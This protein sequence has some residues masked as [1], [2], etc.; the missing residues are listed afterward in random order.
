MPLYFFNSTG[1]VKEGT[2]L[3][4]KVAI[5]RAF[6][7]RAL[8]GSLYALAVMIFAISLRVNPGLMQ[9][10]IGT[11]TSTIS[12]S[13]DDAFPDK[14]EH[15]T[16]I[17]NVREP[18]IS[19]IMVGTI[20]ILGYILI[21]FANSFFTSL[22]S[23]SRLSFSNYFRMVQA[24][25]EWN[26]PLQYRKGKSDMSEDTLL[27]LASDESERER[28]IVK[29][30]EKEREKE[31]DD[32]KEKLEREK[33]REMEEEKQKERERE[34]HV[35]YLISLSQ[36]TLGAF[37]SRTWWVALFLAL[38]GRISSDDYEFNSIEFSIYMSLPLWIVCWRVASLFSPSV[39]S[40]TRGFFSWCRNREEKRREREREETNTEDLL[41]N[42]YF[43]QDE[44]KVNDKER[45]RERR[46]RERKRDS[47]FWSLF[48]AQ[49]RIEFW[50]AFAW[51]FFTQVL[52]LCMFFIHFQSE[53]EVFYRNTL[54]ALLGEKEIN[55]DPIKIGKYKRYRE[56]G[57]DILWYYALSLFAS[58]SLF[59]F[60][61]KENRFLYKQSKK[62]LYYAW[63]KEKQNNA[64]TVRMSLYGNNA[65]NE[66][67]NSD[68]DNDNEP[69]FLRVRS[70]S[71]S[72]T[73]NING[74]N[75]MSS[76]Q[77][78]MGEGER[79]R[80][81]ER[82]EKFE[83]G[84][85]LILTAFSTRKKD[86]FRRM[87]IFPTTLSLFLLSFTFQADSREGVSFSEQ[88]P[89]MLGCYFSFWALTY[90]LSQSIRRIL[91]KHRNIRVSLFCFS[92]LLISLL[93]TFLHVDQLF[94][95]TFILLSIAGV[96]WLYVFIVWFRVGE[97]DRP[98]R[99]IEEKVKKGKR[100]I[101]GLTEGIR[102]CEP[103][104]VVILSLSLTFVIFSLSLSITH[105]VIF[106]NSLSFFTLSLILYLSSS[107][108]SPADKWEWK[109]SRICSAH[110]QYLRY[111][112]SQDNKEVERATRFQ[113]LMGMLPQEKYVA[114]RL[115][116]AER[117]REREY[118]NGGTVSILNSSKE[119]EKEKERERERERER[120][121]G[122]VISG[123]RKRERVLKNPHMELTWSQW[124]TMSAAEQRL[125]ISR[126]SVRTRLLST[127]R[128]VD[129]NYMSWWR[130]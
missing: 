102:A 127:G 124:L 65:M 33:A 126:V 101:I 54:A 49:N 45:E 66:N 92:A 93:V 8:F 44:E 72:N 21:L 90:P 69:H 32:I 40:R 70:V 125:Y 53:S 87:R 56:E 96:C 58:L 35:N 119:K 60:T 18:M 75:L 76:S 67:Y 27:L 50:K 41:S 43:S 120:R 111:G 108:L 100:Y 112:T 7:V 91:P 55:R 3:S 10:V 14:S 2:T 59:Y 48:F 84:V 89:A 42:G 11:P 118:V 30:K 85:P 77:I 16:N 20:L 79:E 130:R 39:M 106:I 68:G 47:D 61:Y 26:T 103:G 82:D 88:V 34:S 99:Y 28:E 117:E 80:E 114:E 129:P 78:E 23:S 63:D 24:T 9:S 97:R 115:M 109:A 12:S 71:V 37:V 46:E 36:Y 6:V 122:N 123:G 74:G 5:S 73:V 38:G 81:R 98:K 4:E 86:Y 94:I 128:C 57:Y 104:P 116:K 64:T 95:L 31:S 83:K 15:T 52:P 105:P 19:G 121:V 1:P 17:V 13:V 110:I 22:F 107:T 113:S 62:Q 29:E 25:I 51:R